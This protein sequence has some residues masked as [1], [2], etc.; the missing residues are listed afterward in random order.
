MKFKT[1]NKKLKSQIDRQKEQSFET[2]QKLS[3]I[4]KMNKQAIEAKSDGIIH[5]NNFDHA[6]KLSMNILSPNGR[7]SDA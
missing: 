4:S 5:L 6:K 2:D 3:L 1:G 7:I